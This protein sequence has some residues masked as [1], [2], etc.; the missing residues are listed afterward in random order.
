MIDANNTLCGGL[1]LKETRLLLIMSQSELARRNLRSP[2]DDRDGR[3]RERND[4]SRSAI[5]KRLLIPN[6]DGGAL[7]R[8]GEL[9]SRQLRVAIVMLSVHPLFPSHPIFSPH[10]THALLTTKSVI[11]T[12]LSQR[13]PQPFSSFSTNERL[14]Q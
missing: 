10:A 5:H 6:R 7:H 14:K 12:A 2:K 4:S 8:W 3:R 9:G 11:S 1:Y 13:K